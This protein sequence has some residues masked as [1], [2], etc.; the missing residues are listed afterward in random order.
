M[1]TS[2][3]NSMGKA[4]HQNPSGPAT[5][6]LLKARHVA[7]DLRYT[8]RTMARREDR[9]WWRDPKNLIM[10]HQVF[11]SFHRFSSVFISFQRFSLGFISFQRFS[12]VCIGFY[13]SKVLIGVHSFFALRQLVYTCSCHPMLNA[14]ITE[15]TRTYLRSEAT[16]KPIL[17][18]VCCVVSAYY[19]GLRGAAPFSHRCR[20]ASSMLEWASSMLESSLG[21]LQR[22]SPLDCF[23]LV[24]ATLQNG[25]R[26]TM[27]RNLQ[28]ISK[29]Q[30]LHLQSDMR[31]VPSPTQAGKQQGNE[32]E[33]APEMEF[34]FVPMTGVASGIQRFQSDM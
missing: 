31:Q 33:V 1:W 16:V 22:F 27:L 11:N 28:S 13:I 25:H 12:K 3:W 15:S 30:G 5:T 10:E 32:V 8:P 29:F 34:H 4:M 7:N 26:Q 24:H 18:C 17:L 9:W 23:A 2:M 6:G 21:I 19:D 20:W 14:I